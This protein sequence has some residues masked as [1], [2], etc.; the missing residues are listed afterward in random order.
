MNL[1][2]SIIVAGLSWFSTAAVAGPIGEWR[3]ADGTAN[4]TIHSCGA[5]LCGFVS[6]TKDGDAI[7]GKPVLLGM[8]KSGDVWTGTIVNVRDGQK[9]NARLS[10]QNE[11]IL[12]VEGCVIGGMICG[13]QQWS[14]LK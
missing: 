11:H 2:S 3:I 13:G 9:Y 14:R 4:I 5:H 7:V 12:K 8:T 6:W 10:L 1:L